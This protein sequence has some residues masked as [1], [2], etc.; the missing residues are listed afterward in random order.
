MS[1]VYTPIYFYP[2]NKSTFPSHPPSL[3]QQPL[4]LRVSVTPSSQSLGDTLDL[5]YCPVLISSLPLLTLP[6]GAL[7]DF[8]PPLRPSLLLSYLGFNHLLL[9]LLHFP[10]S[11]PSS[12]LCH[13]TS[14]FG[15][16][17]WTSQITLRK[18][19]LFSWFLPYPGKSFKAALPAG[20]IP[21]SKALWTRPATI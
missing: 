11:Q 17:K 20:R 4:Q 15:S 10:L 6:Y 13:L 1:Q 19:L 18:Y 3:E 21:G 16:T 2:F 9:Q 14:L 7:P 12:V 5:H 8:L